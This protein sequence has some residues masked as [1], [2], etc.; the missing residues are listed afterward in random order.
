MMVYVVLMNQEVCGVYTKKETAVKKFQEIT[1]ELYYDI[2]YDV[3]VHEDWA[4]G[5]VR[6]GYEGCV[7]KLVNVVIYETELDKPL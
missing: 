2:Y 4:V 6:K 3:D 5:I 7:E 1:E